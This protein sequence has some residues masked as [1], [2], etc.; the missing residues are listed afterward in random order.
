[1]RNNWAAFG[2]VIWHPLPGLTLTGGLRY[3][4]EHKDYTYRRLNFDGTRYSGP[5]GAFAVLDGTTAN[6]DG[7]RL[8]YRGSIDYRFSPAVLA[9]ATVST[10]FKGGGT[11]PR[12]FNAA[13]ADL[14]QPGDAHQLRSRPEDRPVQSRRAVQRLGLLRSL[15]QHPDPGPLLPAISADPGPA[16]C[17]RMPATPPSPASRPRPSSTRRRA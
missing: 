4:E 15:H 5:N 8:D 16:R 11:N 13:Q 7:H 9:Y 12:P 10:G 6:Y 2:T 3:T 17:P 14:V 1:M